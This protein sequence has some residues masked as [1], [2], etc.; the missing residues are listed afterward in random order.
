MRFKWKIYPRKKTFSLTKKFSYFR[1][2]RIEEVN[3]IINDVEN[4]KSG[5]PQVIII[6]CGTN[7]LTTTTPGKNFIS[8]ISA[9]ISQACIKFQRPLEN[10]KQLQPQAVSSYLKA[11]VPSSQA[12]LKYRA[13]SHLV[14]YY[15]ITKAANVVS[16]STEAWA[17]LHVLVLSDPEFPQAL[18]S[19]IALAEH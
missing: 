8:N 7:D 19:D 11:T 14:P 3:T 5:H 16:R 18:S 9:S 6:H 1:C 4:E 13:H 12:R 2:P 17:N 15:R 10:F